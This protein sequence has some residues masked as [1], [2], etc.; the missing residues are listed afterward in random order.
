MTATY[1]VTQADLSTGTVTNT[2][3]A[4]GTPPTGPAV[5]SAPSS[6]KV[7]TSHGAGAASLDAAPAPSS[8]SVERV[9]PAVR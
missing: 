1:T 5:T 9:S 8:R 4:T 3:R 2:A 7:N 6:T